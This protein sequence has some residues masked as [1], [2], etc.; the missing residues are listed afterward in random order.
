MVMRAESMDLRKLADGSGGGLPQTKIRKYT[1]EMASVM[2]VSY[3]HL[4]M[5]T[6]YSV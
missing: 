3:T 4:T 6:I 2:P 5:P 1:S